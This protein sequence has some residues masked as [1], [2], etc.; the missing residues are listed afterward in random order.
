MEGAVAERCNRKLRHHI[1]NHRHKAQRANQKLSKA[2]NSQ[3]NDPGDYFLHKGFTSSGSTLSP[4]TVTP[5]DGSI[6]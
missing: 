2:T 4:Q 3:K 1:L 5:T 6:I